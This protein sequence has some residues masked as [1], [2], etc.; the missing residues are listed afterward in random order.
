MNKI[1]FAL[2]CFSSFAI[3]GLE[4]DEKSH[5]ITID[6]KINCPMSSELM[7]F[8]KSIPPSGE[9]FSTYEEWK[10]S[11]INNMTQLFQLIESEK[12]H[13]TYWSVKADE[14][15]IEEEANN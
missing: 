2:M 10:S 6:I 13:S 8:V 12:V 5:E 14:T 9:Y 3:D 4:C 7:E 15:L 1:M 11:F